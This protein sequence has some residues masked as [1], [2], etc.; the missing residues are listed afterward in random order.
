MKSHQTERL[1]LIA[2]LIAATAVRV[3]GLNN[4]SPPG[5]AHD[6]VANW[7]IDQ[8][9]LAGQHAIYFTQAY[10][11]EAAYHY[12]QT[13]FVALLGDHA[14]ALR[15]PSAFLGVLLVA[16]TFTLTRALLGRRVALP[17]TAVA[18]FLFLPIFYSRLALRAI[19]LPVLSA[20]SAYFWWRWWRTARWQPLIFSAIWAGLA[21]YTYMASRALPIFYALLFLYLILWHRRT[22]TRQRWGQMGA[23]AALY[24]LIALPLIHF[25]QNLPTTETRIAEIDAPMRAFLA[26][27]PQPALANASLITQSFGWQGDALWRENVAGLPIFTAVWGILF[28]LGF[29]WAVWQAIRHRHTRYAFLTLWITCAII[30]SVMSINAPSYIRM[31]NVLPLL[32]AVPILPLF[33]IFPRF[34][35]VF[36]QLSTGWWTKSWIKNLTFLILL[37][38]LA[39]PHLGHIFYT[40]PQE[41]DEVAFVWQKAF[42]QMAYHADQHPE[43]ATAVAGWSPDTMDSPT[44]HLLRQQ[45]SPLRH[46]GQVGELQTAVWP[47][48]PHDQAQILRPTVL[49][50][51]YFLEEKLRQHS[52]IS[53]PQASFTR[54]ELHTQPTPQHPAAVDFGQ[55]LHF[56][57]HDEHLLPPFDQLEIVTYWRVL[58]PPSPEQERRFFL[59]MLSLDGQ[60]LAQHDALAAPSRFWQTG[61][62]I[63]Q[64]HTLPNLNIPYDLH[65][66]VYQP[67]RPWPRLTTPTG[68]DHTILSINN[69]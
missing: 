27:D 62:L 48:H 19:S 6:E 11:H 37:L 5:L 10:G 50:F 31:I 22:L 60:P 26:S 45:D 38:S 57:G 8:N 67:T 24:L 63:L 58:N 17:A 46:F 55:E 41:P 18:S 68:A 2:L 61:D 12:W 65:L 36:P 40:W 51:N 29:A 59:H 42:T 47:H 7:L 66:G 21:T 44:M 9:I 14:F 23:F 1:T 53:Q 32:T 54:Y 3:V 43:H 49:P 15:L 30:P 39:L 69:P 25:L 52:H 64:Y 13:L 56:L 33:H 20:L 16:L 4:F 35:T 34:S 28:Y